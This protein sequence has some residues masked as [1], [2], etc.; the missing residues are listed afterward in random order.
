MTSLLWTAHGAQRTSIQKQKKDF[1]LLLLLIVVSYRV[2]SLQGYLVSNV[3]CAQV[4]ALTEK[5]VTFSMARGNLELMH[6]C[7]PKHSRMG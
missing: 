2:I 6:E 4:V 5:E 1:C 3:S 7:F